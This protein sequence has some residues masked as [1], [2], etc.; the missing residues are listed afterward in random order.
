MTAELVKREKKILVVLGK[1]SYYGFAG[2]SRD[3]E[4]SQLAWTMQDRRCEIP[5]ALDLSRK[6]PTIV[7]TRDR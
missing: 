5:G 4:Q 6:T 7:W 1:S 2:V 3:E